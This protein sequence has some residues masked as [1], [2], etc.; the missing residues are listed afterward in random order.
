MPLTKEQREDI[1]RRV[2]DAL[3]EVFDPELP[4]NVYDLGLI[5]EIEV[6]EE[7]HVMIKMILTAIGC[8]V[9]PTITMTAEAIVSEK[10]PDAKSVN[11]ELLWDKPWTPDRITPDGKDQLS[12]IYGYDVVE[13][14]KKRMKEMYPSL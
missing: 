4:V 2:V 1:E 13:E 5:D 7:G 6:D 8:P 14:W 12:Q 10:V 3:K 9:A 11:V